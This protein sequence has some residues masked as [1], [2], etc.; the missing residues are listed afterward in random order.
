MLTVVILKLYCKSEL[1]GGLVKTQMS[2]FHP[3]ISESVGLRWGLRMYISNKLPSDA[4]DAG[5]DNTGQQ[6]KV[7]TA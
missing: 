1:A 5:S 3:Q 4:D 2:R 7:Q 6:G